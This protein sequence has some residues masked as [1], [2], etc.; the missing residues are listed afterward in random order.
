MLPLWQD[1]MDDGTDE[2]EVLSSLQVLQYC[3]CAPCPVA[4][5]VHWSSRGISTQASCTDGGS[6]S[7]GRALEK[8]RC[9]GR[10]RVLVAVDGRAAC[11]VA[12]CFLQGPDS[13]KTDTGTLRDCQNEDEYEAWDELPESHGSPRR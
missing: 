10:G 11:H 13:A 12:S 2:L 1:W 3:L 5:R 4:A 8:L 7:R 6:V 9:A